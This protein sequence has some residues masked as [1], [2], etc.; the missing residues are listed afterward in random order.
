MRYG[1]QGARRPKSGQRSRGG[2]GSGGG[3]NTRNRVYESNGPEGRVRGTPAQVADKYDGLAKDAAS[4]GDYVL[5]QSFWQHAEHYRR[6]LGA[7][8]GDG[9]QQVKAENT[10]DQESDDQDGDEGNTSGQQQLR[11]RRP[12]RPDAQD[13]DARLPL[14]DGAQTRAAAQA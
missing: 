11:Q 9:P 6:V 1:A 5:A 3:G 10:S 4:A 12:R 2:G 13:D 7:L 14:E 8:D